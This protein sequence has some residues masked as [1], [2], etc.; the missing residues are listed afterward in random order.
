MKRLFSLSWGLCECNIF[1]LSN[2]SKP[3]YNELV[4]ELLLKIVEQMSR[5]V[6]I[7]GMSNFVTR[8][9]LSRSSE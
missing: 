1:T 3:D 6:T 9:S 8:R 7:L 2:V 5:T 4:L